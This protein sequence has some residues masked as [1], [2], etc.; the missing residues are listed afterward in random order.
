MRS[1]ICGN[2]SCPECRVMAVFASELHQE[3][4]SV[5][6]EGNKLARAATRLGPQG[7]KMPL[8]WGLLTNPA[9]GSM[10]LGDLP[11]EGQI[12]IAQVLEG[13]RVGNSAMPGTFYLRANRRNSLSAKTLTFRKGQKGPRSAKLMKRWVAG[14]W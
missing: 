14:G 5:V 1:L 13:S 8:N 12:M 2:K 11:Q 3:K 4:L 7:Q 9:L 6:A 10:G